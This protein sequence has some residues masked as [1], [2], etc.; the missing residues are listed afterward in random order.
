[1]FVSGN[2]GVIKMTCINF[3]SKVKRENFCAVCDT[4]CDNYLKIAGNKELLSVYKKS[5][6]KAIEKEILFRMR[7]GTNEY[8]VVDDENEPLT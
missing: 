4:P 8:E 6:N 1:L 5:D 3:K 7:I 2:I